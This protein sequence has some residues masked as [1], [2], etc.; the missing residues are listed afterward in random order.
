MFSALSENADWFRERVNLFLMLAPVARVDRC[1]N[2]TL[3]LV[4]ENA[5]I[6]KMIKKMGPEIM[7]SPQVSGKF[8]SGLLMLTRA[9]TTGVQTFS[10]EDT[11]KISPEGFKNYLGHFPAGTSY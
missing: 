8:M 9:A 1:N 7:P 6:I 4:S 11:S 5:T 3:R 10:D 2:P